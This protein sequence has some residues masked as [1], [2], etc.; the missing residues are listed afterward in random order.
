LSSVP[1]FH[2]QLFVFVLRSEEYYQQHSK[3]C[4]SSCWIKALWDGFCPK[5]R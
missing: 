1:V 5:K 3:V 2:S 4:Q